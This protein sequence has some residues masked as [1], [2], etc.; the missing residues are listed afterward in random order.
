MK[1]FNHRL[2]IFPSG[3]LFFSHKKTLIIW[4]KASFWAHAVKSILRTTVC[5]GGLSV[6]CFPTSQAFAQTLVNHDWSGRYVGAHFGY[7]TGSV[8][9]RRYLPPFPPV[10]IHVTADGL[11]GGIHAGQNL[12][13]GMFVYGLEADGDLSS[14]TRRGTT[15]ERM[16]FS[17][18]ARAGVA[19]DRV[20]IFATG[21]AALRQREVMLNNGFVFTATKEHTLLG[22]S[23]GAGVQYAINSNWSLRA[24]FRFSDFGSSSWTRTAAP[25]VP[26]CIVCAVVGGIGPAVLNYTFRDMDRAVRIG[27]TR[28]FQL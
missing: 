24:E 8:N 12:Q 11:L 15:E 3:V 21:G 18:R 27:V 9:A 22:Y 5:I 23:L 19:F 25:A 20:L 26:A 28:Q 4:Y 6:A 16:R 7:S 10:A 17:L 1:S 2:C 13:T 14:V